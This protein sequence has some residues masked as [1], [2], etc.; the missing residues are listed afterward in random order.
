MKSLITPLVFALLAGPAFAQDKTDTEKRLADLEK[1]I[2]ELTKTKTKAETKAEKAEARQETGDGFGVKFTGRIFLDGT[3]FSGGDYKMTNGAFMRVARLGWKA[4]LGNN[5]YGEG[6]LDFSLNAVG[7]KD[8]WIGYT[9]FKDSMVQLGHFKEPFGMDTLMSDSNI[10]CLER[11]FTDTWTPSRHIGVGYAKWGERWQG[12]VAFFGQAIDDTSDAQDV[13]D[14]Y[15]DPVSGLTKAYKIV[16]NQGYGSAAR[17]TFLPLLVSDN[18]FMHLGVAATERTPNAGA[19]G[20]YSWDFSSRPGTNKQSKAK[21]L[22]ALVTNVD[23]LVQTGVEFAGQWGA[24][25]WQSEYQQTQVKRRGTQLTVWNGTAQVSTTQAVRDASTID[26]KFSTYYGQVSYVIGGERRYDAADAFF[27]GVTPNSK[28]GA[29]ELVARYNVMN[30]DD[31]TAVDAV[32]GGIEK[33]TT[34]GVNYYVN[35][36]LR[37]MLDYT[38]V[39]NNENAFAS[40]K[41]S[42]TGVV[43]PSN[44]FAYTNMRMAVTF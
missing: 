26:H 43:I 24:F 9:G 29:W 15:I 35:K 31:I 19:P 37:F 40:K 32:K 36:Y 14:T 5:W 16:D 33:N 8:M 3:Y 11:S 10:W 21:F 42:S 25:S 12:K 2:A 44:N 30:Q 28:N 39:K 6:E 41:Y 18:K 7:V 34:V 20:D 23:K 13:A 22:N 4:T 27:K 38:S 17:I 1:R